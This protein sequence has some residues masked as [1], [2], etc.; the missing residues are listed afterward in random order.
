M[1]RPDWARIASARRA[2][3]MNPPEREVAD[4]EMRRLQQQRL[5]ICR[6]GNSVRS[7]HLALAFDLPRQ[8]VRIYRRRPEGGWLAN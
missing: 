3:G 2:F 7:Q 6:A 5:K 4:A 8:A 1:R